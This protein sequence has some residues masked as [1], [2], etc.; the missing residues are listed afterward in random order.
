VLFLSSESMNHK[1]KII[2][3]NNDDSK[4]GW[5]ENVKYYD[6]RT[7]FCQVSAALINASFRRQLLMILCK[8]F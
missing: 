4:T 3:V 6:L 2:I 1:Q 7:W 5:N 8:L